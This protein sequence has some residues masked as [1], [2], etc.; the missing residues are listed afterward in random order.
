M[1]RT[2]RNHLAA[3]RAPASQL[4]TP[5]LER[6]EGACM[7]E[8]R[9]SVP[10]VQSRG[11]R[12]VAPRAPPNADGPHPLGARAPRHPRVP[13]VR[14]AART[15][16][17]LQT[18]CGSEKGARGRGEV[19]DGK[20]APSAVKNAGRAARVPFVSFSAS[21]S[22]RAGSEMQRCAAVASSRSLAR[23]DARCPR[24]RSFAPTRG[25]LLNPP[26]TWGAARLR[27]RRARMMA[28]QVAAAARGRAGQSARRPTLP[29]A[30]VRSA[31]RISLRSVASKPGQ[32]GCNY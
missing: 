16:R 9:A 4:H 20:E 15:G 5:K 18:R 12:R 11:A 8:R 26:T 28:R 25:S 2:T 7:P 31:L 6:G 17:Y 29:T 21:G 30:R 24:A 27:R 14:G 10:G 23:E 22:P 1:G 13:Q 32:R 19:F 3:S